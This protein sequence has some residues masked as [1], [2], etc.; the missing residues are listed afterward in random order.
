MSSMDIDHQ[1]SVAVV[2]GAGSGIGAAT[3]RLLARRGVAVALLDIDGDAA[4]TVADSLPAARTAN[5]QV[6]QVDVTDLAA[7]HEVAA[8][9]NSEL[10][11]ITIAVNNAGV[12]MSSRFADTSPEDW[13]WIR[14]INLD[15]VVNGCRAFGLPMLDAGRGHVVNL[16][17]GLAYSVR[18]TE[19]FYSA[20]KAAV[21]SLSRSLRADWSRHGVGVSAICP[22]VINTPIYANTRVRGTQADPAVRARTQ[23]LFSRGHRPEKVADAIVDAIEHNRSVV[24]VGWESRLAWALDGILPTALVDAVARREWL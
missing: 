8:A 17:S 5:H 9:V 21:L 13:E 15:G 24:P 14:S 10:G 23:R 3:A 7:L 18:P 20:T 22:G 6:H 4:K 19:P 1:S 12:G 16:S 11:P 2:T